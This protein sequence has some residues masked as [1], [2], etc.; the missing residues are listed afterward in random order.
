MLGFSVD[1]G[2]GK[3]PLGRRGTKV[4]ESKGDGCRV[5]AGG[6]QAVTGCEDQKGGSLQHLA[7]RLSIRH[8]MGTFPLCVS[9]PSSNGLVSGVRVHRNLVWPPFNLTISAKAIF[10]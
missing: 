4:W 7:C 2:Q 6:M 9:H 10:K 1:F 8:D 3:D 5:E